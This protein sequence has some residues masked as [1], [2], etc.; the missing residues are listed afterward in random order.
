MLR[1]NASV[2][3]PIPEPASVTLLCIGFVGM[4]GSALRRWRN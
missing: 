2:T 1:V 3:P 4:A